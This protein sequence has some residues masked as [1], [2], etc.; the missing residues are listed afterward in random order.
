M[1]E[2]GEDLHVSRNVV[3]A[4]SE[5]TWRFSSSG[6]P[7]GQH[8]NTSNTRVE[9]VVRWSEVEQL[10]ATARSRLIERYGVESVV[11]SSEHRSQYQNRRAAMLRL[12]SLVRRGLI[13]ERARVATK[14]TKGSQRRRLDAKKRQA[15][16]KAERRRPGSSD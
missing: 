7:G 15:T 4:A 5:M 13:V 9:L 16:R 1:A 6:G 11:V 10:S 12:E 8:A 2:P 14:P 3:I